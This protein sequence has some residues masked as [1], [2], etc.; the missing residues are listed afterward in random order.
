MIRLLPVLHQDS[1]S[2]KAQ[3]KP[4]RLVRRLARIGLF[5]YSL[6]LTH[7]IVIV[8]FSGIA[9]RWCGLENDSLFL[10]TLVPVC[11]A[12]AWVFFQVFERP[13]MPGAVR[14]RARRILTAPKR[15]PVTPV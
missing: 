13:F 3:G 12:L 10:L 15:V 5:S 8:H 7:E 11:L 4:P 14:S 9:A 2:W 6:Y 1:F